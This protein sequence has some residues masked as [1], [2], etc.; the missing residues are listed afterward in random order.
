MG[1]HPSFERWA[2]A[3]KQQ[4]GLVASISGQ[5]VLCVVQ[6]KKGESV[7]RNLVGFVA[8]GTI[9]IFGQGLLVAAGPASKVSSRATARRGQAI[10]EQRCAMCHYSDRVEKKV[11]PGLKGIY[12]RGTF[13]TNGNKITDESLKAWIRNGDS[14]M[15]PFEEV[16]DSCQL[17]DLIA[18]L[19]TL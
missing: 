5:E 14:Q 13:S 2:T 12:K 16:L 6:P 10:F 9:A 11:G 18:F 3:S 8:V 4:R 15:P 7:K 17:N 1:V 19:K